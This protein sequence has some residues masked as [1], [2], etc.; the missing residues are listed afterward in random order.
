M[1]NQLPYFYDTEVEWTR[2]RRGDLR[3]PLLPTIGVAAPP[4]FKGHEG[5]WTPEHL[6][7]ASVNSCFVTTFLA[8]AE[9]SKIEFTSFACHARGRLEK[10]EGRGYRI[11]GITLWPKLVIRHEHDAERAARLLEKAGENCLISNS[12][13][14]AVTLEP[15]ITSEGVEELLLTCGA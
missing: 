8:V 4:E 13:N 15:E 3:S 14:T 2:S 11:T 7:V 10:E 9:L 12:I 5:A 1:N 6:Y